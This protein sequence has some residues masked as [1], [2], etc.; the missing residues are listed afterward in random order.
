MI[1]S[2]DIEA[3]RRTLVYIQSHPEEWNPEV[4]VEQRGDSVV[5]S[6]AA[7]AVHLAGGRFAFVTPHNAPP[8]ADHVFF[9]TLPTWA[10]SELSRFTE[11]VHSGG[12]KNRAIVR[13]ER[14]ARFLL[15]TSVEMT[16]ALFAP[17]LTVAQLAHEVDEV[18]R[19]VAAHRTALMAAVKGV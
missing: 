18:C 16:R 6:F 9:D 10:Q 13:V 11:L 19:A 2:T 14:T 8:H 7:T 3:I 17:G 4:C 5:R 12:D 15:A 1:E